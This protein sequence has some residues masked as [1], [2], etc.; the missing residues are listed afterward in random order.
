MVSRDPN[1]GLANRHG[2]ADVVE[3]TAFAPD[4]FNLTLFSQP[5]R[6]SKTAY[7]IGKTSYYRE[8]DHVAGIA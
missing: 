1:A 4:P 8:V 5:L 2:P 6:I 3:R 7:Y